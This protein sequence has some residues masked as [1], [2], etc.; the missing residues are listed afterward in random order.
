MGK[1]LINAL[2]FANYAIFYDKEDIG[3]AG[4]TT[5]IGTLL[6]PFFFKRLLICALR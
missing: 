4:C 3:M 1:Y 6:T 5:T 2:A